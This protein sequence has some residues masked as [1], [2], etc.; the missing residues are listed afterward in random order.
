MN[1]SPD[2]WECARCI[3]CS[4]FGHHGAYCDLQSAQEFCFR[5]ACV[6]FQWKKEKMLRHMDAGYFF[7]N[8]ED[9]R[10]EMEMRGME[11][12]RNYNR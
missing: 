4:A 8:Y 5:K 12:R 9:Y 11:P 1:A 7:P 10:T 6:F 2:P 3:D